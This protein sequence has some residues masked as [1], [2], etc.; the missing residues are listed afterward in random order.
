MST[1]ISVRKKELNKKGYKDFQDWIKNPNH[2]Y[3]GRNMNFYV[4]GTFKSKWSNP[5]TVKKYGL[6]K[7]LELYEKY[8]CSKPELMNSLHELEN[9]VLGCWCHDNTTIGKIVCHGDILIK[10]LKEK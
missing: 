8:I 1:V 3:I 2:I 6:D 5:Y 4:P 10:L 7:C 9:K